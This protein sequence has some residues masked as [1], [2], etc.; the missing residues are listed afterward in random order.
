MVIVNAE[1]EDSVN[2]VTGVVWDID[3]QEDV[4]E[5]AAMELVTCIE[6]SGGGAG[7]CN[8]TTVGMLW[9]KDFVVAPTIFG[10]IFSLVSLALGNGKFVCDVIVLV[11]DSCVVTVGF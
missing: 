2:D 10:I 8:C 9:V 1:E 3:E 4:E 7:G 11:S 5:E 6:V